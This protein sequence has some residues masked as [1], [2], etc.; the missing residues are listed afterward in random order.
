MG[1]SVNGLGHNEP[2]LEE[3]GIDTPPPEEEIKFIE[4]VGEEPDNSLWEALR[5]AQEVLDSGARNVW[6]F[7]KGITYG[8][9][10][11]DKVEAKLEAGKIRHIHLVSWEAGV[12]LKPIRDK[13]MDKL[14]DAAVAA[15]LL[16]IGVKK[17]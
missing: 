15:I 14:V 4:A 17:T 3:R 5:V 11:R 9:K 7:L 2:L 13:V 1:E 16:A 10:D 12:Q 6:Y 8:D